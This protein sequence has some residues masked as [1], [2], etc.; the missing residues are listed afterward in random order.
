MNLT[1]GSVFHFASPAQ[2]TVASATF[3]E[4]FLRCR[5]C[6]TAVGRSACGANQDAGLG[7]GGKCCGRRQTPARRHLTVRVCGH[8]EDDRCC[9]RHG[10]GRRKCVASVC[11]HASSST[12]SAASSSTQECKSGSSDCRS[13]RG[14]GTKQKWM[15][16]AVSQLFMRL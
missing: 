15:H 1:Y 4:G 3:G 11:A 9:T 8:R 14:K 6:R 7:A 2:H 10:G 13:G 16:R 5:H 12:S